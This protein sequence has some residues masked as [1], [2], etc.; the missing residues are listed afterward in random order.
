[1]ADA[2]RIQKVNGLVGG[3]VFGPVESRRFGRSLGINP[4]PP[5]RKLCAFDCPYCEC[6]P[7][8]HAESRQLERQPFP[9]VVDVIA[10]LQNVMQG[11]AQDNTAI[12]SLTLTGNG[13]TTLHPAFEEIVGGVIALRDRLLPG[14]QIVVLTNGTRL[15]NP[16]VRRAL[17][18]VDQCVVKI[19]AGRESTFQ[20]IN[21]PLEPMTLE[22]IA[23][24]AA[25]LPRVVVQTLFVRGV[26]DNT[27]DVEI[28]KWIER[29]GHIHPQ[30]VQIYSLD[31]KPAEAGLIAV[32][33]P[34]LEH[35]AERLASGTQLPVVV[36]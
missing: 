14:A 36:Y 29:V 31:R 8:A 12:D 34:D 5:D 24:A 26:V 16:A 33:R 10:A 3:I 4:L 27:G 25:Q 32:P 15:G 2:I 17:D 35:I 18:R 13:E 6:G 30:S 7:T 11:L 22:A 21:R 19:D 23:E 28:E 20:L 1:M 9:S